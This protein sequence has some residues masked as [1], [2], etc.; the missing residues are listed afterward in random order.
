MS[1]ATNEEKNPPSEKNCKVFNRQSGQTAFH[2]P[3]CYPNT[4]FT[5][6]GTCWSRVG[7]I[8]LFVLLFASVSWA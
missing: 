7:W 6:K 2:S 1:I 3:V 8:N 5:D 4:I